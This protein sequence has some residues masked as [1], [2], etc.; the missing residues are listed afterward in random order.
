MWR[1]NPG[2]SANAQ[3]HI[4]IHHILREENCRIF[5]VLWITAFS[6]HMVEW[7]TFVSI[8]QS[9]FAHYLNLRC[10][11]CIWVR[12]LDFV[13]H[14]HQPHKQY[15]GT[16]HTYKC[17]RFSIYIYVCV[18]TMHHIQPTKVI[19]RMFFQ[20]DKHYHFTISMSSIQIYIYN[21]RT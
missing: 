14:A 4:H 7:H 12:Q 3:L 1:S 8:L 6:P 17:K 20:F 16:Q 2:I 21:I 11:F 5:E 9:I 13:R 15:H 10:V 18:A 19:Y